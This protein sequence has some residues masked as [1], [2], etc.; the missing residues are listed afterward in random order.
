M[1]GFSRINKEGP[2]SENTRSK[3]RKWSPFDKKI[4]NE[5]APQNPRKRVRLEKT[6]EVA[7]QNPRKRIRR[8][9]K[10][11]VPDQALSSKRI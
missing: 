7:P 4:A 6:Q 9:V 2:P 10:T 5:V 11:I 8:D 1:D 3:K